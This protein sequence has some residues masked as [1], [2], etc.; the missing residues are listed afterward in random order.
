MELHCC[1][2]HLLASTVKVSQTTHVADLPKFSTVG[3]TKAVQ[4]G[5]VN[6][7]AVNREVIERGI[8]MRPRKAY[9][10]LQGCPDAHTGIIRV[11][12]TLRPRG[13]AIAGY[14]GL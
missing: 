8:V 7:D 6:R 4:P 5:V 12:H 9:G 10:P 1:Y 3:S 14:E 13:V 11:L 2:N